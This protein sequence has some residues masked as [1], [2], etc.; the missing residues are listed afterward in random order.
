MTK[1][2]KR[3]LTFATTHRQCRQILYSGVVVNRRFYHVAFNCTLPRPAVR[4]VTMADGIFI[5]IFVAA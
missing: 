1:Q 4:A 2:A 3:A 5:L